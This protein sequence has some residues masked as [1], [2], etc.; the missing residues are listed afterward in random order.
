MRHPTAKRAS[1]G[2]RQWH[3]HAGFSLIELLVCMAVIAV[4][5]ALLFPALSQAR[6]RAVGMLCVNNLKQLGVVSST[7]ILDSND[8][9]PLVWDGSMA[10][11]QAF[12]N[13]DSVV[14][15]RDA[16][17]LYCP[18]FTPATMMGADGI[19]TMN[20]YIY[21]RDMD[22]NTKLKKISAVLNPSSRAIYA[23]SLLLDAQGKPFSQSYHFYTG[24]VERHCVHLRHFNCSNLWF[25]DGHVAALTKSEMAQPGNLYTY[26]WK[27]FYP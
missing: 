20:S 17:W 15:T 7:Y 11:I 8:F 23:D 22:D 3:V 25:V 21:G 24:A 4:L 2:E 13:A 12:V 9:L 27:N 5:A 18:S 1:A 6:K 26:G 16:K 14:W 19:P 10:W